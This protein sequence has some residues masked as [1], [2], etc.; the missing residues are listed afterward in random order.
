M[1]S[2]APS[3]RIHRRGP[4]REGPDAAARECQPRLRIKPRPA[5][6]SQHEPG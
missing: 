5:A 2:A 4:N 1:I 6:M 3:A